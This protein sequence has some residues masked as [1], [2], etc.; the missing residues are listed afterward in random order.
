MV[1]FP[2]GA[3]LRAE[4]PLCFPL[5]SQD[6][7]EGPAPSNWVQSRHRRSGIR[8]S[9]V[10]GRVNEI[11]TFIEMSDSANPVA[12]LVPGVHRSVSQAASTRP[13]PQSVG[14]RTH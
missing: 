8:R 9:H 14:L 6:M 5:I 11:G 7:A 4:A 12:A 2:A 13:A 3:D 10:Q 1:A